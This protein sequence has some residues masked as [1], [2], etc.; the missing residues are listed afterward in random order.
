MNKLTV[1]IPR[2]AEGNPKHAA[3]KPSATKE[4]WVSIMV[5]AAVL[6]ISA[7][8][9]GGFVTTTRNRSAYWQVEASSVAL[10]GDIKEGDDLNA[11]LEAAGVPFRLC[12]ARKE[13]FEPQYDGHQQKINPET[14]EAIL[15]DGNAVYL[16]DYVAP[17]GQQDALIGKVAA[18][19]EAPAEARQE[20]G[21][22]S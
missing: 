3:V 21:Q 16:Q 17:F 8:K 11:K 7:T 15:V 19:E 20:A 1:T 22:L 18:T 13:S 10:L 9:T 14:K 2:D 4:G 12:I 6:Q 5:F